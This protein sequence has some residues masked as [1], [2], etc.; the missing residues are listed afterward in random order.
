MGRIMS[1]QMWGR[2]LKL[3]LLV[4]VWVCENLLIVET[5]P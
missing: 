5:S 1:T 2:N 4:W 3:K